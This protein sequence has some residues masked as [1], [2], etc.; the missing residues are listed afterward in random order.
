MKSL[1][2]LCELFGDKN[3]SWYHVALPN[4]KEGWVFGLLITRFEEK[5]RGESYKTIAASKVKAEKASFAEFGT[6]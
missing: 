5:R 3:D 1:R 2:V 6:V 4:G